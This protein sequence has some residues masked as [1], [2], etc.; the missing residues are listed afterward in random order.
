MQTFIIRIKGGPGSGHWGHAGRPGQRGGGRAGSTLQLEAGKFRRLNKLGD[1][2]KPKGPK[3]Y[4]TADQIKEGIGGRGYFINSDDKLVDVTSDFAG[5]TDDHVGYVIATGTGG[6]EALN[7]D[8]EVVDEFTIADDNLYGGEEVEWGDPRYEVLDEAWQ[9]AYSNLWGDIQASGN[10]R[11]RI[12]KNETA[13][14]LM[15]HTK[16]NLKRLQNWV[17]EGKI[18]LDPKTGKMAWEERTGTGF[19]RFN[20]NDLMS[21]SDIRDLRFAGKS[22]NG[23]THKFACFVEMRNA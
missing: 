8:Q 3:L 12:W 23:A 17:L 10:T 14:D 6:V 2:K 18:P 4:D 9:E 1:L 15:P 13:V 20:W 19:L 22:L 11:V 21:A 16:S 5:G 7:L